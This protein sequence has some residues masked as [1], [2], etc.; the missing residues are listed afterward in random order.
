MIEV[1]TAPPDLR[2]WDFN[3]QPFYLEIY[4]DTA[5]VLASRFAEVQP[6]GPE[7]G[8]PQ[9]ATS[10]PIYQYWW[11]LGRSADQAQY[12]QIW[13]K[14]QDEV[15]GRV[16]FFFPLDGGWRIKELV[17]TVNYLHPLRERT[18]WWNKFADDWKNIFAP[19]IADASSLA[20]L[21]PN[22]A[23]AGASTLLGT[24]AKLQVNSVPQ[25]ADFQWSVGKTTATHPEYGVLQGV[26]W[27][28]PKRMFTDLGSRLTGSVALS[29]I[30]SY[31]QREDPR[32]WDVPPPQPEVRPLLA[33]AVMYRP[34]G[35]QGDIWVPGEMS[36]ISL[37]IRPHDPPGPDGK[38]PPAS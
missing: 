20:G 28:L 15:A 33:H 35:S 22:P 25:V 27:A 2:S 17:A 38:A 9:T 11:T 29:F 34:H 6:A 3:E 4:G 5:P 26:T 16:Y 1:A 18:D 24:I 8:S 13:S 31:R 37:Q 23:F 32:K 12:D 14:M 10:T 19:T 36:F 7:D 30:P 21:V